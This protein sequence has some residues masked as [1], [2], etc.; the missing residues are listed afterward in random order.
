MWAD[1]QLLVSSGSSDVGRLHFSGLSSR[2]RLVLKKYAVGVQ[3]PNI[4]NLTKL[5]VEHQEGTAG[6]DSRDLHVVH[7]GWGHTSEAVCAGGGSHEISKLSGLVEGRD[8]RVCNRHRAPQDLSAVWPVWTH[9]EVEGC[10]HW[11]LTFPRPL[12]CLAGNQGAGTHSRGGRPKHSSPA[13][14]GLV[15]GAVKLCPR[16]Y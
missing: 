7:L 11:R 4:P 2:G 14:P 16:Q 13:R 15:Y 1:E 8:G 3:V 9:R 10:T 12:T 6:T 5:A